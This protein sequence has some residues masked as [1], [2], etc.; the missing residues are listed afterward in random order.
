MLYFNHT[1][2]HKHNYV[3]IRFKHTVT[4]NKKPEFE[5]RDRVVF[6][7]QNILY[8]NESNLVLA[9]TR[10]NTYLSVRSGLQPDLCC[11]LQK[12]PSGHEV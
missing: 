12:P 9:S 2:I 11:D 5:N 1:I 8:Y 10:Q 6:V 4:Y 3:Y 7:L